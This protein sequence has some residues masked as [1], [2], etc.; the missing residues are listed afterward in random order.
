MRLMRLRA[1][2]TLLPFLCLSVAG[3]NEEPV[4]VLD[5]GVVASDDATTT[6][7]VKKSGGNAVVRFATHGARRYYTSHDP[8][9]LTIE[10]TV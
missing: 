2:V 3:D 8:R 5:G 10:L 1:A 9:L 6:R 4:N 7:S